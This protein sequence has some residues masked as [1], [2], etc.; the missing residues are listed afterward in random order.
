MGLKDVRSKG[1]G[2]KHTARFVTR[3]E[4][5]SGARQVRRAED[6]ELEIEPEYEPRF[7]TKAQLNELYDLYRLANVPLAGT[8]PT[9]ADRVRWACKAF[10][11]AHPE[12][13]ENGAYKDLTNDM[14]SRATIG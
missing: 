13:S 6:R 11:E 9:R 3:A 7:V 1:A 12:I 5:R 2:G 14:A 4:A 8:A 10:H